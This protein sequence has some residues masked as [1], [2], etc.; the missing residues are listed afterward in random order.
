M[1][2]QN[3]TQRYCKS[4]GDRHLHQSDSAESKV[5]EMMLELNLK[6]EP[7]SPWLSEFKVWKSS[8]P[9]KFG[10]EKAKFIPPYAY[11]FMWVLCS[12]RGWGMTGNCSV[13]NTERGNRA[14]EG[15]GGFQFMDYAYSLGSLWDSC[16]YLFFPKQR[17][18]FSSFAYWS[19]LQES[20]SK[21]FVTKEGLRTTA[22][23]SQHRSGPSIWM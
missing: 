12:K 14:S 17:F 20:N 23:C 5:L 6:Y 15:L 21:R 1:L 8:Q 4:K 11:K 13:W 19:S 16:M 10:D 2:W 18:H 3:H 22:Q 9:A 7:Q